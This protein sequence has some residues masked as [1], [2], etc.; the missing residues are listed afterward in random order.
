MPSQF[1][2]LNIAYK[3]LLAGNAALNTTSNNISNVQTEGYSRQQVIQQASNALRVFQTYGCA[4]AGVETLAIERI[5]DEFYDGKFWNNNSRVG[6][7]SMKQYYMRQM[8]D[9]FDDTGLNAGFKSLFDQL[10]VTG[11]QELKKNPG[12]ATT[13]AQFV[14]FADSLAEYF[15]GQAGNLEKMQ[16]DVNQEIKLK[17][18]EINSLAAEIASLNKQINTVELSTGGM[19]NELRDRRTLLLD[20]LSQIVDIEVKE[21]PI[22]DANNPDRVTGANNFTVKIAGG[23]LLVNTNEYRRLECVARKDYEKVNQTDIDGLYDIYWQDGQEFKLENAA[24][25]GALRGLVEMRDGN[26]GEYFHGT[27]TGV[28]TKDGHDTVTIEVGLEYLKDLNKCN[29]SDQGGIINLGNR[30]FYYD[31]WEYTISYDEDGNP[32]YSYTFTLSDSEKNSQR[33]T[34]DRVGMDASIGSGIK[35]QGIPYYM[36]QMNEWVRT[37]AQKFN[38]IL[39]SGFTAENEPGINMF[40]GDWLADDGQYMFPDGTR[41]DWYYGLTAEEALEKEINRIY[42]DLYRTTLA[43]IK[44]TYDP[45]DPKYAAAGD[46]AYDKAAAAYP[47]DKEKKKIFDELKAEYEA[48][49]GKVDENGIA[50]DGTNLYDEAAKQAEDKKKAAAEAAKQDAID[51]AMLAD[52]RVEIQSQLDSLRQQAEADAKAAFGELTVSST[53]DSYYQLTAKNFAILASMLDDPKLLA[54][55]FLGGDGVEQ[56]DLIDA[57]NDMAFDKTKMSFRG[58]SASEFLQ[59]ILTDVALNASSANLFYESYCNISST[60]DTQRISI[61]GVDED[62]EAVNMVKYQNAYN[63]AAKMIQTLTEVYDKLILDTGV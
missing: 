19:A 23:Q 62:E 45:T 22:I 1:F 31:S 5:R 51:E 50:D 10:M 61:S 33:L 4:G 20:Q 6:E 52:A 40:V 24:M 17:V 42:D 63:L 29:L 37:F 15:N 56:D 25:G 21:F 46:E 13:R 28:G 57:L 60:I 58:A 36:S 18:D 32:V 48:K 8:E 49:G 35:Y 2:G 54:T 9:Y 12:D 47:I 7:Y 27:V 30:E 3:G 53:T 59:C 14:G 41:Y 43:G 55:K 11:L 39:K 16:K 44:D 26:N 34:N 38:D